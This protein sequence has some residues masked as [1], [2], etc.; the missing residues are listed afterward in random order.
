MGAPAQGLANAVQGAAATAAL[1]KAGG[2]M[3]GEV[4]LNGAAL[5]VGGMTAGYTGVARSSISKYSWTNAMVVALGANLAGDITVCTLP[6][7]T[8]VKRV[9]VVI[10]GAATGPTTLTVAIGRTGALYIDYIIAL[11]AKA[12][13]NTIY[14]AVVGDLGTNLTGYDLPSVT[15]TT[16][17]KAHFL[18]TVANLDQTLASTGDV[19]IETLTLP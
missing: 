9:W 6:A 19:Y 17:V 16:A 13:A 8:V 12:T 18:A 15:G 1:A 4:I 10:T 3:T 7:K 5:T 2:T 11:T 14:G